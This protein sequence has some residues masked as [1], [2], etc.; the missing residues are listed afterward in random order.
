M[1][2]NVENIPD[3]FAI[4][5]GGTGGDITNGGQTGNVVIGSNDGNLS[6]FAN[7]TV[8]IGSSVTINGSIDFNYERISTGVSAVYEITD[9]NYLLEIATGVIDDVV[10]PDSNE[11]KGRTLIIVNG[12]DNHVV[13]VSVKAGSGDMI[14]NYQFIDLVSM[15]DRV[16]VISSGDNKWLLL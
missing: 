12:M 9:S 11:R 1:S 8:A 16:S 4:G 2:I 6:L 7:D 3:T 5:G 15:N 10:L 13:R 14:D